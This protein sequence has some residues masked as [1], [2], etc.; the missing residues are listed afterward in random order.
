MTRTP[1]LIR[2][3][4]DLNS[5]STI[6]GL[7]M[8]GSGPIRIEADDGLDPKVRHEFERRLNR[9][10]FACGCDK[11]AVGMAAG[12]L[13]YLGWISLRTGGWERLSWSDLWLGLAVV[14]AATV[15]GKLV[16]RVQADRQLKAAAGELKRVWKAPPRPTG[17]LF[18]CG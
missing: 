2:H 7:R 13:G 8:P 5:L 17:E 9:L 15:A 11:A 16:G 14:F 1:T 18:S 4:D 12:I 3:P 6:P 10:Y